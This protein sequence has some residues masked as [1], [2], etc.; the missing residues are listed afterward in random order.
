MIGGIVVLS[1][2]LIAQE[3][4]LIMRPGV[5]GVTFAPT[6]IPSFFPSPERN[7]LINLSYR[8]NR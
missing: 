4:T 3:I 5:M 8:F 7:A 2:V 1:L 6:D